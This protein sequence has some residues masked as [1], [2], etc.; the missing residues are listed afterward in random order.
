MPDEPDNVIQV[1][2]PTNFRSAP[3][4]SETH[5]AMLRALAAGIEAARFDTGAGKIELRSS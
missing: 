5:T 4:E 1:R 2:L 3:F